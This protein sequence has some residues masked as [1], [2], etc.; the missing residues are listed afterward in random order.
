MEETTVEDPSHQP[1]GERQM[2]EATKRNYP[3]MSN[4]QIGVRYVYTSALRENKNQVDH[5]QEMVSSNSNNSY[6]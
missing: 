3:N 2:E 5:L 4:L 1:N 6:L